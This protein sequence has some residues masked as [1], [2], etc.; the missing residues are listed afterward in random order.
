MCGWRED[1]TVVNSMSA[2]SGLGPNSSLDSYGVTSYTQ[3]HSFTSLSHCFLICNMRIRIS[4]SSSSR[5]AGVK[6]QAWC[7]AHC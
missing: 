6:P 1:G 2:G 3:T 5:G 4:A 7:L